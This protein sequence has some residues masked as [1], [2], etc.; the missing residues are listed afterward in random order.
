MLA[1]QAMIGNSIPILLKPKIPAWDTSFT[2][3]KNISL[4]KKPLNGG[5]P[6]MDK[7][8]TKAIVNVIGITCI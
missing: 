3:A 2:A 8:P 7:P 1:T 4:L 5:N 6:A